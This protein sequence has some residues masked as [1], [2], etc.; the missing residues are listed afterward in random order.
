MGFR[1][2]R[3]VE[4]VAGAT[5]TAIRER[6]SGSHSQV[7]RQAVVALRKRAEEVGP[8]AIRLSDHR[9]P[10]PDGATNGNGFTAKVALVDQR[11]CPCCVNHPIILMLNHLP[12][13]QTLGIQFLSLVDPCLDDSSLLVLSQSLLCS[14]L[15]VDDSDVSFLF[16]SD[17]T[18]S[19]TVSIPTTSSTTRITTATTTTAIPSM[20]DP[21]GI[22]N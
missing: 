6:P 14:L 8:G 11:L 9:L 13:M 16:F 18:P 4:I 21:I 2:E 3:V 20:S 1:S 15:D 12:P 7:K 17:L 19:S 5:G 22:L 10:V